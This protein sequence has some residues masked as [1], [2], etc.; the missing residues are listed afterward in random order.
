MKGSSGDDAMFCDVVAEEEELFTP[1]KE[2]TSGKVPI[3]RTKSRMMPVAFGSMLT[4]AGVFM[5]VVIFVQ[6]VGFL[7]ASLTDV[8]LPSLVAEDSEIEEGY[9]SPVDSSLDDGRA[10]S[11]EVTSDAIEI[12]SPTPQTIDIGDSVQGTQ[13]T[14]WPT[15]LKTNRFTVGSSYVPD[16]SRAV[17]IPINSIRDARERV[18]SAARDSSLDQ[19]RRPPATGPAMWVM[20]LLSLAVVPVFFLR[21]SKSQVV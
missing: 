19:V 14:A 9:S 2:K 11:N 15:F 20:G 10:T 4:L 16:F 18:H 6:G 3:T 5:L 8:P 12:K 21:G 7:Q 1:P 13:A 17:T